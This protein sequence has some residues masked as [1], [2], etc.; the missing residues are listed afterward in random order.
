MSQF[1]LTR[2]TEYS[3]E[4]FIREIQRVAAL[5]PDGTITKRS[6]DKVAHV[7]GA[8][9][10]RHF[11]SWKAA[12]EAAGLPDR[13]SGGKV[14]DRM[15]LQTTKYLTNAALL[16]EMKRVASVAGCAHLTQEVFKNHSAI[17]TTTIFR[18]FGSWQLACREAGLALS[19]RTKRY[20]DEE[21]FENL[22]NLWTHYGRQPVGRE[23][24]I[25]PST[26]GKKA[27]LVRWGTWRRAL[28]AFVEWTDR[29]AGQS[30]DTN[31][32]DATHPTDGHGGRSQMRSR[33]AS[34]DP[35]AIPVG[36]RYR[37]LV[38][39]CFR[40]VICG[41]SPAAQPGCVLHIDHIISVSAGGTA[42][43]ENLRTLCSQCNLGKG[44]K[45]EIAAV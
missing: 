10:Q 25:S 18:R 40:C 32:S 13:Y 27:Y 9:V 21:C 34:K 12:L 30:E 37:V 22:L 44:S 3:E 5:V 7:S 24:E 1:Q 41:S 33:P 35:R 15:K 38:R 43:I 17:H 14:T 19:P 16:D 20:S 29:P 31:I 45:H 36:V 42:R 26:V 23:A 2:L 28:R 8:T 39:D 4:A 11:G 6:F